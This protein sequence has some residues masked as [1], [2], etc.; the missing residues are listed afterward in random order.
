MAFNSIQS[1]LER[2][3]ASVIASAAASVS[4][5]VF[6]GLDSDA[7]TLPNAVCEAGQAQPPPGLQFT[8]IQVVELMVTVR[9]NKSDSTPTQHEA[10][11]SAIFDAL[12]T[13]TAAA[14]LSGGATDF[15]AF[16]VEFGASSQSVEDDSHLSTM[17]FRVTCCPSDVS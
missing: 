16:M 1:K 13:D 4:C 7:N 5:A 15:T 10:R 8:G 6:T 14:D 3:A 2:A 12:T 11:A 9:S 17:A